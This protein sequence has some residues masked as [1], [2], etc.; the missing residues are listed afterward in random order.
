M[1]LR[2]LP[3]SYIRAYS[4]GGAINL[5]STYMKGDFKALSVD[6]FTFDRDFV[7]KYIDSLKD[8]KLGPV[9]DFLGCEINSIP[10]T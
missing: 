5:H 3:R 4:Y 6:T 10:C 8:G 2:Q 7:N 9:R 1:S